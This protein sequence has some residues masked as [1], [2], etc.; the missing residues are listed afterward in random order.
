VIVDNDLGTNL[1]IS[2]DEIPT[3]T[4]VSCR[5]HKVVKSVKPD[6]LSVFYY[7]GHG[8]RIPVIL[9]TNN[10]NFIEGMSLIDLCLTDDFS[11]FHFFSWFFCDFNFVVFF[12]SILLTNLF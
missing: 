9:D 7:S 5:I 6:D 11:D 8:N 3:T 1:S 10:I 12:F 4:V 2:T